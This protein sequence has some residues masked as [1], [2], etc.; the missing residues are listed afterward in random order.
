MGDKQN[1][2]EWFKIISKLIDSLNV[3]L[4]S[5]KSTFFYFVFFN[6]FIIKPLVK[7]VYWIDFL[8]YIL[9]DS[10]MKDRVI[11]QSEVIS[12]PQYYSMHCFRLED[13]FLIFVFI[14]NY[15]CIKSILWFCLLLILLNFVFIRLR[16]CM[17]WGLFY[18]RL[19]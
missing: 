9:F 16:W 4:S 15:S 7:T 1:G 18:L 8:L 6:I 12:H 2:T 19:H 11:V 17:K 10:P 14:C 3:K 13:I 5:Y